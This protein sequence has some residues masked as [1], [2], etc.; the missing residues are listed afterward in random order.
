MVFDVDCAKARQ[1][2][3]PHAPGLGAAIVRRLRILVSNGPAARVPG[4][5]HGKGPAHRHPM[6][7]SFARSLRPWAA[8]LLLTGVAT[9]QIRI[10]TYPTR[11]LPALAPESL[12]PLESNDFCAVDVD[13]DG[14]LDLVVAE[15]TGAPRL[16]RNRGDGA[17]Q[18]GELLPVAHGRTSLVAAGDIDGDGDLDL[19]F[20]GGGT[21]YGSD[22]PCILLQ[23]D[24]SGT[25]VPYGSIPPTPRSPTRLDV[26]DLDGDGDLDFLMAG[27][28][29]L[30]LRNEGAGVFLDQTASLPAVGTPCDLD[31]D[32]VLDMVTGNTVH[33]GTGGGAFTAATLPFP[34]AYVADLDTDGDV[35]LIANTSTLPVRLNDGT[36]LNFAAVG[37]L[38][39]LSD[40]PLRS[41][42]HAIDLDGDGSCELLSVDMHGRPVVLR[43]GGDFVFANVTSSW[44]E[45]QE[46]T[47]VDYAWAAASW[48]DVDGDG[49]LDCLTGVAEGRGASS[50]T[51]GIP[52]RLY[53]DAGVAPGPRFVEATRTPFPRLQFEA[54]PAAAGDVD[55]DGD[56]DL[57][58]G[59][60]W[61]QG[62]DGRY[63]R[64]PALPPAHGSS[65]FGKFG[66]G[67]LRDFDG[68]ADLDLFLTDGP[69]RG[70]PG[71]N[72]L[73]RLCRNLG[74]GTFANVA[75]PASVT[76]VGTAC[77]AGDVDG[78]GDLDL[79][80]G[81]RS[82]DFDNTGVRVILLRNE[83]NLTFV[84]ATAQM[85]RLLHQCGGI[86]LR[87]LDGD[88]D[89]DLLA[90]TEKDYHS[91]PSAILLVNDGSGT[92][93]DQTASRIPAD[94]AAYGLAVADFDGD[95]DLDFA[96]QLPFVPDARIY[97][98]AGDGTFAASLA[99]R[100]TH[101][102]D[103]DGDGTLV[104]LWDNRGMQLSIGDVNVTWTTV[105]GF[106]ATTPA[107]VL[108]FDHD[109][110]GDLDLAVGGL[111]NFAGPLAAVEHQG[112]I[113][114]LH[115]DLRLASQPRLGQ[116][117]RVQLRAAN[118]NAATGAWIGISAGRL[119]AGIA[120]PDLGRGLLVADP[121]QLVVLAYTV[122]PDADTVV[123]AV[124]P[125][126]AVPA[127]VDVRFLTQAL[128]VP[129]GHEADAHFSNVVDDRFLR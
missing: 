13:G 97:T 87:D 25:F 74:N 79:V 53:L 118:G 17:F 1:R 34:V 64:G 111:P 104:D 27:S 112:V 122:V 18:A 123:E 16:F 43:H 93:V 40:E 86:A 78:D 96:Q 85:P 55:G 26:C 84:D 115:R 65:F 68:D 6:N 69:G 48:F 32:G 127:I 23:N 61:L 37:S 49:D 75:L 63:S 15:N 77:D 5:C 58:F 52:P 9:S 110:D 7:P 51:V 45:A 99:P 8:V 19:F 125:I 4:S 73:P 103:W 11:H 80:L 105:F 89:L 47:G 83:G 106:S 42:R 35:D 76:T 88:G 10:D 98:N 59:G 36:G 50:T 33:R 21:A 24:G 46:P 116:L 102:V 3:P 101:V 129:F 81:A 124:C 120:M 39:T 62:T 128:F 14:D 31:G 70:L 20:C 114:N 82:P 30:Y 121:G 38:P 66:P 29:A 72:V 109:G 67:L 71:S 94:P 56:T 107:V 92:F 119:P 22:R 91:T 44:F 60:L 126:P 12:W 117:L 100:G 113:L 2:P 95:G 28:P 90:G 108:P 54:A 41:T 57:V